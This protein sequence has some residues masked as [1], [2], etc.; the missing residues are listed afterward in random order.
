MVISKSEWD[1]LLGYIRD[2]LLK[3]L[4]P[5]GLAHEY[6]SGIVTKEIIKGT[7]ED[8]TQEQFIADTGTKKE[9]K[10]KGLLIADSLFEDIWKA[11]PASASFSYRGVKFNNS[12]ILRSNRAVCE[13]LYLKAIQSKQITGE[14]ILSAIKKQVQ[15]VK[16][17]SYESGQ[18]RMQFLPT[19][20][21]YLRQQRYEA[22]LGQEEETEEY[23][24]SNNC[25]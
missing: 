1:Q 19:I 23:N 11:Y 18:N 5:P 7:I 14:Q 3:Q 20:E 25:A 9:R 16:E 24:E 12:R 4:I 8:I 17:E 2:Q 22:I 13:M 15:M 21:V 10:E 6:A